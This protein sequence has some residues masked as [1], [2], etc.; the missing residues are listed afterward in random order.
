M[1][2]NVD[3]V[4]ECGFATNKLIPQALRNLVSKKYCKDNS[5]RVGKKKPEDARPPG[6]SISLNQLASGPRP[7]TVRS[8]SARTRMRATPTTLPLASY[9][10]SVTFRP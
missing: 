10:C 6:C 9:S 2:C 7:S 5:L 3:G 4:N 8:D 1:L